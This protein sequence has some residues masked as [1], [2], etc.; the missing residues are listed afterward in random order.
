ML[1]KPLCQSHDRQSYLT[2]VRLIVFAVSVLFLPSVY[3]AD[4]TI[5]HMNDP[6]T[7]YLPHR[8]R[9][10]PEP[11][12]G[13]ARA[14]TVIRQAQEENDKRGRDTLVLSAGDLLTG[15]PFSEVWRGKLGIALMNR[16]GFAAMAVGNHEFDYGSE[17]LISVLEP[18][19]QFPFLSANIFKTESGKR[20]FEPTVT[21]TGGR[22]VIKAIIIGLTTPSTK[23]GTH[24]RNV[25]DLS[26][27]DQIEA[28]NRQLKGLSEKD[29][30][31][32][33]TH[34]GVDEDERLA[35]ACPVIDVIVGG[36]SHT[37]LFE[38]KQ[39]GD[40][41]IVQAGANSVY[42]GRLDMK[43]D[44]G[45]VTSYNGRLIP[46]TKDVATDTQIAGVIQDH[47]SKMDERLK[48]VIGKTEI[49]L[50]G[51]RTAVMHGTSEIGKMVVWTMRNEA[52]TQAAITNAGGIRASIDRGPITLGDV[53]TV[54]PFENTL[55]TLKIS[56]KDLTSALQQSADLGPGRG[57]KL[58]TIGIEARTDK[59]R[60]TITRVG[61]EPYAADAVYSVVV[62]DYLAAGG[63]GYDVFNNDAQTKYQSSRLV[64]DLMIQ[65]IKEKKIITREVI[66]SL[67]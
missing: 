43:I 53:Y 19:A 54:L 47:A 52:G 32:A 65:F 30:L 10:F 31:I 48:K 42:V 33:L 58:M 8:I 61:S 67:K 50:D 15:T 46:L 2:P 55:A 34:L 16:M 11:V 20:V 51:G 57:G 39:I 3:A 6:H 38:P 27:G 22:Q 63:D 36:H 17:H 40:T 18:A 41:L 23:T 1:I 14:Q 35:R 49:F 60:I 21:W 45:T 59:D 44:D 4:V 62:N 26:F 66:N 64:T 24:P 56:G 12:G 37:A 5:L 25:K 13:F 28:A 7:H 29:F 9:E